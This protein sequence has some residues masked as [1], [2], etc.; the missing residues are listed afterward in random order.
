M[1]NNL[2]ELIE[3]I[4]SEISRDHSKDNFDW[5]SLQKLN[6]EKNVLLK[7]I[8]KM[9]FWTEETVIYDWKIHKHIRNP[10]IEKEVKSKIGSMTS[11]E[12]ESVL[13]Y[14]KNSIRCESYM[15]DARCRLCDVWLGSKDMITPDCKW[16]YPEKWEHY[17]TSHS[18]KPDETFIKDAMIWTNKIIPDIHS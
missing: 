14:M 5:D 13:D 15:G 6:Y 12:K 18:I 1:K 16:V 7:E 4:N 10:R 3:T 8:P 11:E 9:G 17:I 2:L